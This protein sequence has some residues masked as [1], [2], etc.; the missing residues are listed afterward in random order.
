MRNGRRAASTGLGHA[1]IPERLRSQDLRRLRRDLH[2]SVGPLLAAVT[3]RTE[4]ASA[5]ITRDP[6]TARQMLGELHADACSALA[7]VRRLAG[8][9]SQA[10]QEACLAAALQ[11]QAE[12]FRRAS[13][14]GLQVSVT[15][16]LADT[17]PCDEVETA[18]YRIATEALTNTARH[19]R[20]S[21]CTIRIW[22]NDDGFNLEVTDDGTGLP[23]R[24]RVGV[25]LKSMRE[26][27]R[28]LGGICVI[29]NVV[30][31]GTRVYAMVPARRPDLAPAIAA[32]AVSLTP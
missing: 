4:A 18:L 23:R 11:H 19:A 5:I 16:A 8:R 6:E 25:G 26:R 31:H 10:P 28:E 24:R 21:I 13:G 14:G 27:A 22:T 15:V 30:P 29:G 20:A 17:A 9:A 7:E 3:M 2:D 32:P 1:D 12:R